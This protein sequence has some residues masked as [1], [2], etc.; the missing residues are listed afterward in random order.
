MLASRATR[1]QLYRVLCMTCFVF[2]GGSLT[3]IRDTRV[4]VGYRHEGS[5]LPYCT[6][7]P[8]SKNYDHPDLALGVRCTR[9]L[10]CMPCSGVCSP[11]GALSSNVFPSIRQSLK[12]HDQMQWRHCLSGGALARARNFGRRERCARG[13]S[14]RGARYAWRAS[15]LEAGA[16]SMSRISGG[17]GAG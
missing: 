9:A 12:P 14:S 13:P 16:V 17:L 5:Q 2:H 6:R 11:K 10:P 4:H 3:H 1:P 8:S 7:R 15:V